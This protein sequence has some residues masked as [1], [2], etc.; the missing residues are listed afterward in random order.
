VLVVD[1]IDCVYGSRDGIGPEKEE[2]E[3]AAWLGSESGKV[4]PVDRS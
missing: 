3:V 4:T 2:A 1:A